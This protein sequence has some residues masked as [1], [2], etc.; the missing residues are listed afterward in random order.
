M[1]F[2]KSLIVISIVISHMSRTQASQESSTQP[3]LRNQSMQTN[4]PTENGLEKNAE[5][6]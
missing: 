1:D 6:T 4:F 2:H 5:K 3:R